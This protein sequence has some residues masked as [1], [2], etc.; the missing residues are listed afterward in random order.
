MAPLYL[1]D[2]LK[3]KTPKRNL[4]SSND[5]INLVVP[6][7]KYKNAGERSFFHVGPKMFNSLPKYVR[8][9]DSIDSFKRSLKHHLFTVV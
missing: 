4:R 7:R 6:T 3:F 9:S 5:K 2:S 8:E 1:S